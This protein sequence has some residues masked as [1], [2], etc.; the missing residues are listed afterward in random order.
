MLRILR[1]D[2]GCD[3]DAGTGQKGGFV[4][5]YVVVPRHILPRSLSQSE[6]K[7]FGRRECATS[8]GQTRLTNGRPIENNLRD[9]TFLA[10]HRV[11]I[12]RV[13]LHVDFDQQRWRSLGN[14]GDL[15][16]SRQTCFK[17]MERLAKHGRNLGAAPCQIL[18][19]TAHIIGSIRDV[20]CTSEGVLLTRV[21]SRCRNGIGTNL[22]TTAFQ[23][24]NLLGTVQLPKLNNAVEIEQ[25]VA[26]RYTTLCRHPTS[27]HWRPYARAQNEQ[28]I[29]IH[30][31]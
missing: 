2:H 4:V 20:R 14:L 27:T 10:P 26:W 29:V 1:R 16:Q 31:E 23:Q 5:H 3:G 15:E 28:S 7:G 8:D 30:N 9:T 21:V 17:Q 25:R 22:A 24:R 11:P 19:F 18:H 6:R 13:R 12:W